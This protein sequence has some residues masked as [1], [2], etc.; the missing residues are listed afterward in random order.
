[1]TLTLIDT[2]YSSHNYIPISNGLLYND[3]SDHLPVFCIHKMNNFNKIIHI[4][5]ENEYYMSQKNISD[6]KQYLLDYN[7]D[8]LYLLNDPHDSFELFI[9]IL[10]NTK[11][12]LCIIISNWVHILE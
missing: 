1:M 5:D 3:I 8:D 11:K 6:Y 9:N 7:W 10:E 12:K 4:N 2:I